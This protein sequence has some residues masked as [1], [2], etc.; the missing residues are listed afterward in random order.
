M[1]KFTNIIIGAAEIAA[2]VVLEFVPGGQG[3]GAFLIA[4]GAG[5]VIGGI[6]TLLNQPKGGLTTASRNPIAPRQMIYGRARIPGVLVQNSDCEMS[7]PIEG[8]T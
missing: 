2:G 5:Q 8:R 4:A 6:G 1:A 3:L 7:L